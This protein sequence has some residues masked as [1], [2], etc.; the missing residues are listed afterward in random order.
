VTP[1]L[2]WVNALDVN[3]LYGLLLVVAFIESIFPPAPA[4]VVVAF[5]AFYAARRGAEFG[6]VVAVIVTGS[7][8]GSLVVYAV[9]RKFGADWMHAKMQRLHMLNAE[10]RL[11][12]L[13]AHYGLAALFVSRFVPGLRAVVSPMAGA[14]RVKVLRYTAVI[15]FASTVWYGIIIWLGFR[16]GAD[17]ES[18]RAGLRV[19]G[20]RVGSAA[21]ILIVVLAYVGWRLWQRHRARH[22]HRQ[23]PP[24]PPGGPPAA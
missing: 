18:V 24:A 21:S 11:E 7:V 3:T 17:W 19:V 22:P 5:G 23:R 1:L 15:A 8:L 13:Y 9:A 4:D 2:D 14:L 10:E 16:V 12:G 6:P 20:I